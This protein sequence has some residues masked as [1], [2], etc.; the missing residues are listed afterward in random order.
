MDGEGALVSVLC[1]FPIGRP[2]DLFGSMLIPLLTHADPIPTDGHDHFISLIHSI[3][4]AIVP[5]LTSSLHS[6]KVPTS[7]HVISG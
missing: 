2:S 5:F 7:L 3:N 1:F 4:D 6:G